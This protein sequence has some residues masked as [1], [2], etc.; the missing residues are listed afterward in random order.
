MAHIRSHAGELA[1]RTASNRRE[2]RCMQRVCPS[3]EGPAGPE[4]PAYAGNPSPSVIILGTSG[5]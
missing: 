5:P 3:L 2:A 4:G 1:G